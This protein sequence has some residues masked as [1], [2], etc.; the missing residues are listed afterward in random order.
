MKSVSR[1]DFL[2]VASSVS[3]G[4]A[5]LSILGCG[6]LFTGSGGTGSTGNL[7]TK[8]YGGTVT[9]PSGTSLTN[10]KIVGPLGSSAISGTGFQLTAFKDLSSMVSV[11]D[12]VNGKTIMLGM[13][14]KGSALQS[15]DARNCAATL[16][17]LA[18]G[19]SQYQ[20]DE[21]QTFWNAVL[22][23]S[24]LTALTTVVNDRITANLFALE[25]GDSQIIS[26]L[27]TAA[28]G[29][30][31]AALQSRITNSS[32]SQ[33]TRGS[34]ADQTINFE[35]V[36]ENGLRIHNIDH[37]SL[38]LQNQTRRENLLHYFVYQ[39][40]SAT[41]SHD[42]PIALGSPIPMKP[43]EIIDSFPVTR[44]QND[45]NDTFHLLQLTP[46][47]DGAEPDFFGDSKYSDKVTGWRSDLGKLYRRA[48][49][50][51][52][53]EVLLEA[54]GMA[55]VTL[56]RTKVEDA[57]SNLNAIGGTTGGIVADSIR[58][59]NLSDAVKGIA[60]Q[61]RSGDQA[62]LDHL[63]AI[64][65]LVQSSNPVLYDDLLHRNYKSDQ[66]G[67]FRGA[68]RLISI[69]GALSLSLE[70]GAEYKDLTTGTAGHKFEFSAF[71]DYLQLTPSGGYYDVNHAMQFS[72]KVSQDYEGPFTYNW[73]LGGVSNSGMYDSSGHNGFNFD[74]DQNKVTVYTAANST[75]NMVVTVEAFRG[76][77][78]NKTSIGSTTATLRRR[79]ALDLFI[80]RFS[81]A[82][83]DPTI[84][85][86]SM[87][88]LMKDK[89]SSGGNHYKGG[90]LRVEGR[91]DSLTD[92]EFN[93]VFEMEF[94]I[95]PFTGLGMP[96]DTDPI[97]GTKIYPSYSNYTNSGVNCHDMGDR[98]VIH[99][100]SG[101]Y[102]PTDPQDVK[103]F[104][105]H[106]INEWR[107]AT[108]ATAI[109][110]TVTE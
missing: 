35:T 91:T 25:D 103:D 13:L 108:T 95:P 27:D 16:L 98:I 33:K 80:G 72:V 45:T 43:S 11:I 7:I 38:N 62:A 9:L 50:G 60:Q 15:I 37:H 59:K 47:F 109:W 39:G 76:T 48:A 67:A 78:A 57:A 18:L 65:T 17:F 96:E 66:L 22:A 34:A 63:A 71:V 54:V 40:T 53:A 26:A 89:T 36:S 82:A 85:N 104:Q 101:G 12:P 29:S 64:A 44:Y 69:T 32:Q 42:T 2:S 46:V 5:A 70:L 81:R 107:N 55:G 14:D 21:R 86:Y 83:N 75:G 20:G 74:T 90:K 77:G 61:A 6:G 1:R 92:P 28:K 99:N 19:G 100:A 68:L 52:S 3:F 49:V 105:E 10:L 23:L 102:A 4:T 106:W 51:L 88:V 56:E 24:T 110:K 73:R 8:S 31:I 97:L 58:G 84:Y 41:S 30:S 93:T 87:A 79:G 94:D